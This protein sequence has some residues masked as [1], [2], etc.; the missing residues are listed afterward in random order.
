M[1]KP[2]KPPT[3]QAAIAYDTPRKSRHGLTRKGWRI[4]A[5]GA[6]VIHSHHIVDGINLM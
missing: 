4:A 1:R 5:C 3:S 6:N 2:L